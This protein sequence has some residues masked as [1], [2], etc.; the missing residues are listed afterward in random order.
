MNVTS[1]R[2]AEM[3]APLAQAH[4]QDERAQ[5]MRNPKKRP[6]WLNGWDLFRIWSVAGVCN[7]VQQ[8]KAV[9]GVSIHVA[10]NGV[11]VLH[12]AKWLERAAEGREHRYDPT[13]PAS[14]LETRGNATA[15]I[16]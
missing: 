11:R 7:S 8:I 14:A 10:T 15:L 2:M 4:N 3:L 6:T 12:E 16:L 9:A 1:A 13:I 5:A